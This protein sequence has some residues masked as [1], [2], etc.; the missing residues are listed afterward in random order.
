MEIVNDISLEFCGNLLERLEREEPV[1]MAAHVK[2]DNQN[3]DLTNDKY[4]VEILKSNLCR[5]LNEIR[6]YLGKIPY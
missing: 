6:I 4:W 2:T 3:E 1:S 5:I